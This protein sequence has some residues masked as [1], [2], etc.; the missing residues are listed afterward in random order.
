MDK[1]VVLSELLTFEDVEQKT[2]SYSVEEQ[3]NSL[4][5][6]INETKLLEGMQLAYMLR[7]FGS[8]QSLEPQKAWLSFPSTGEASHK[9]IPSTAQLRGD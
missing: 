6:G 3:A 2:V 4:C 5:T 7:I 8:E 9:F 1:G